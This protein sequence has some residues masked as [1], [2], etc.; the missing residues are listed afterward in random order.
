MVLYLIGIYTVLIW[1]IWVGIFYYHQPLSVVVCWTCSV[2]PGSHSCEPDIRVQESLVVFVIA[3]CIE[4]VTFSELPPA[5]GLAVWF[6]VVV[7]LVAA[8]AP[9]Q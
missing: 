9:T 4:V 2:V 1:E 8:A 6:V 5:L 7:H 3:T